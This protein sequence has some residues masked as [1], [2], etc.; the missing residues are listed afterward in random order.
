MYN[1]FFGFNF[2]STYWKWLIDFFLVFN[3]QSKYE[4]MALANV[5]CGSF[6]HCCCL[7]PYWRIT[8]YTSRV[9]FNIARFRELHC[10]WHCFCARMG[11][12]VINSWTIIYK[13]E[14]TM[15]RTSSFFINCIISPRNFREFYYINITI[16]NYFKWMQSN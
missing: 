2:A 8:F 4:Y 1:I 5:K 15:Q 11:V 9:L 6:L 7:P 16:W 10:F 3:Q 13:R 12:W 14:I